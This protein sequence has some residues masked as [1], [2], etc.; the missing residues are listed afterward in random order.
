[1]RCGVYGEFEESDSVV[2]AVPSLRPSPSTSSGF[3]QDDG[4]MGG[5]KEGKALSELAIS[6]AGC[7]AF[8]FGGFG[9]EEAEGAVGG[10]GDAYAWGG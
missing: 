2:P 7:G 4:V 9:D 10:F 8:G 6:G 3:A 5:H 1:M